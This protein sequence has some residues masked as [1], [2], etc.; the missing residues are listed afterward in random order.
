VTYAAT[1]I[2]QQIANA[3]K[4]HAPH[5]KPAAAKSI[6]MIMFYNMRAMS[7]L[8]SDPNAPGARDELGTSVRVYLTHRLKP[9]T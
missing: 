3:L 9:K 6:A 1:L 8:T 4:A 7:A 5:L 2:I